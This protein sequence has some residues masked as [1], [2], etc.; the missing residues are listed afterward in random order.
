MKKKEPQ[1]SK[2]KQVL[3]NNK[4]PAIIAGFLLYV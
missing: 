3:E 4:K 1:L 2:H